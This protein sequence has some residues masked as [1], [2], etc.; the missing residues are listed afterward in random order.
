MKSFAQLLRRMCGRVPLTVLAR[1]A[2]VPLQ[3]LEGIAAGKQL[4]TESVARRILGRGLE[5]SPEDVERTVLGVLLHDLGLRDNEV[6]QLVIAEILG[7]L[8]ARFRARLFRL[9]REHAERSRGL[10][11]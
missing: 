8:P 3:V 1:R 10:G 11:G 5:L 4:P 9:A 7:T 2:Q 6:R